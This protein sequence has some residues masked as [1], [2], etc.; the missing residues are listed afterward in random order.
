MGK[1][2]FTIQSEI[3][4]ILDEIYENDGEITPELEEKLVIS[5]EE[6]AAKGKSYLDIIKDLDS[7]IAASKEEISRCQAFKKTQ[8]NKR[9][10]LATTLVDAINM[11]GNSS[12]TGTKFIEGPTYK[13]SA[14]P[15]S[16]VELNESLIRVIISKTF[17][18]LRS[19]WENDV[20]GID[21]FSIPDI[22]N[23]VTSCIIS[24]PKVSYLLES[25]EI[26]ADGN[27]LYYRLTEADFE[28]IELSVD[29]KFN[30]NKIFSKS[31][32]DLINTYFNFD[33]IASIENITSKTTCK[34]FM[35]TKGGLNIAK[36]CI[37]Y[38][39]SIK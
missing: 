8:E 3:Y 36:K 34:N 29:F 11:F 17:D 30:F 9:K 5:Q 33:Y 2:L 16:S 1:S 23:M 21:D 27:K 35:E 25:D 19:S 14:R 38:S 12:K 26:D 15:S 6:L 20:V 28:A 24:D 32:A 22:C 18:I 4:Q 7:K 39:L 37:N 13:I 31:F 10:R